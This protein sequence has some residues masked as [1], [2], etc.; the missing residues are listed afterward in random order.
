M[1]Q[2]TMLSK[3]FLYWDQLLTAAEQR[4]ISKTNAVD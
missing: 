2:M 3:K 4:V 1:P